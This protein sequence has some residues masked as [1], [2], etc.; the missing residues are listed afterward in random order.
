MNKTKEF[1]FEKMSVKDL[2][3]YIVKNKLF[4]NVGNLKKAELIQK[5]KDAGP[6]EVEAE[7]EPEPEPEPKEPV[8][9]EQKQSVEQTT[10]EQAET[11]PLV[12]I[13]YT[14]TDSQLKNLLKEII[15]TIDKK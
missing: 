13:Y 4:K 10:G 3:T 15:L 2:R 8:E 1:S 14:L 7:A 9:V 5:I 12:N 6:V 11:R